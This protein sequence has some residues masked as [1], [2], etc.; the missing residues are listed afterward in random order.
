MLTI[1]ISTFTEAKSYRRFHFALTIVYSI[2]NLGHLM[3]DIVVDAPWYQLVLMVLLL[4]IGLLLN[5]VSFQWQKY[6]PH[7]IERFTS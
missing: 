7:K 1:I 6:R 4:A 2:L 3:A 5:L